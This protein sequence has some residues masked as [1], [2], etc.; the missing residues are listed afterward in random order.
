MLPHTP[1]FKSALQP[2][3][4]PFSVW[5][6]IFHLDC[7][8]NLCASAHQHYPLHMPRVRQR[9]G[10]FVRNNAAIVLYAH[11]LRSRSA[12]IS[13]VL[14][15]ASPYFGPLSDYIPGGK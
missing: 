9:K 12:L 2:A 13:S 8:A 5:L 1:V 11:I 4:L 3:A 7:R 15:N 14:K 6:E 10:V